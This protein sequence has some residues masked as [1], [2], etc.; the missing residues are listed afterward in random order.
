MANTG[1]RRGSVRK[2]PRRGTWTVVV[3][4]AEVGST[5]RQQVRRRGFAT[6]REAQRALTTVVAELDRTYFRCGIRR[7][8]M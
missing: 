8:R 2:D 1:G 5:A 3:D 6:E 7:A 4:T